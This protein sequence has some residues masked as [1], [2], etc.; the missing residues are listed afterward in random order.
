[1][2][3]YIALYTELMNRLIQD[4]LPPKPYYHPDLMVN[5]NLCFDPDGPGVVRYKNG[6]NVVP[7]VN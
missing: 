5:N 2:N 7:A 3:L 6:I 4:I 1:M